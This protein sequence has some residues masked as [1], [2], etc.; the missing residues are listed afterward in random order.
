M[1]QQVTAKELAEE[2]R[3]HA[4]DMMPITILVQDGISSLSVYHSTYAMISYKIH[5]ISMIDMDIDDITNEDYTL[6]DYSQQ[7]I[8]DWSDM[9]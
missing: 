8:D 9:E 6:E 7:L 5:H 4:G 3:E 2:I 1:M